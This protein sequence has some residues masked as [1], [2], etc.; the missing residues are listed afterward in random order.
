MHLSIMSLHFM[1]FIL[2]LSEKRYLY[3]TESGGIK[4]LFLNVQIIHR[5]NNI[6]KSLSGDVGINLSGSRAGVPEQG[7]DIPDIRPLLKQMGCK[8][9]TKG[10]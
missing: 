2:T 5:R 6:I 3:P 9:V 1:D 4:T 8:G 10:M 7:L